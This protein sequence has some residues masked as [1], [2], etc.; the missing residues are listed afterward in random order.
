MIYLSKTKQVFSDGPVITMSELQS[1]EPKV[2]APIKHGGVGKNC[3]PEYDVV[4]N[5][6]AILPL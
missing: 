1:P 2:S 3:T 6:H 5:F 4:R